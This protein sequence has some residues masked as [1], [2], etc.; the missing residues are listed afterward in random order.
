MK[1][2]LITGAGGNLGQAVVQKFI[3]EGYHVTGTVTSKPATAPGYD[4]V[5]VDLSDEKAAEQLVNGIVQKNG[6][7]DVAVLTVGGFA[8]G[9]IADTP[10]ADILKQYQLNFET[11]YHVARPV[12][13]QMLKQGSGRIFLIGSRPGS[14][15]HNSKG[16]VGYGMAKSLLFRL[17]ELLNDEAKGHDVVTS[18]VVPSTIDT[19]QN[20][21]AM[22]D[23]DF[24]KWVKAETIAGVIYFYCSEEGNALREPVIKVYNNA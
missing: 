7:I 10:A 20:R 13:I 17:A 4:A 22:P 24:N 9:K 3:A 1:S 16:M 23:A 21:A 14:D 6:S 15:M 18:V 12:F 8:M 19:P 2:A 5:P 11:A